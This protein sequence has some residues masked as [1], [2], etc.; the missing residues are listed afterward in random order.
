MWGLPNA[1]IKQPVDGASYTI[2]CPSCS[3][4]FSI[5]RFYRAKWTAQE[6]AELK[7]LRER[8]WSFGKIAM[9]LG[10]SRNSVASKCRTMGLGQ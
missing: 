7:T 6:E 4:A 10:R 3:A 5:G 2:C 9:K 8:G 1:T